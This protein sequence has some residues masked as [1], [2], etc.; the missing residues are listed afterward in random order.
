MG[1]LGVGLV[2]G[3]GFLWIVVLGLGLGFRWFFLFCGDFVA[4]RG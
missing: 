4:D 1:D 3:F 2:V